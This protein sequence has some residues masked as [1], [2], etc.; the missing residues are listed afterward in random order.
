MA[1][2]ER[3]IEDGAEEEHCGTTRI[4]GRGEAIQFK[5]R[6]IV[7]C[8][9]IG[10]FILLYAVPFVVWNIFIRTVDI[11]KGSLLLT[12]CL[13]II[14]SIG[15]ICDPLIYIIRV[16]HYRELVIQ[17]LFSCRTRNRVTREVEDIRMT[18]ISHH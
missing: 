3:R 12:E 7:P 2:K 4:K 11:T 8:L 16:K 6:F 18:Q 17:K 9:I 5:R 14:I 13:N 1:V 15:F 10:T